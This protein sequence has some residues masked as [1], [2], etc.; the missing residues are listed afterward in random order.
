MATRTNILELID[1]KQRRLDEVENAIMAAP[2]PER[3]SLLELSDELRRELRDLQTLQ[4][5]I[6]A[7][8]RRLLEVQQALVTLPKEERTTWEAIAADLDSQISG[9][10]ASPT[11][12][13]LSPSLS[14]KSRSGK[15]RQLAAMEAENERLRTEAVTRDRELREHTLAA[16]AQAA[17]LAEARREAAEARDKLLKDLAEKEARERA[18]AVR[19]GA[20]AVRIQ[21]GYRGTRVRSEGQSKAAAAT[22][23]QAV[24]RGGRVREQQL[25]QNAAST[26]IQAVFRG[27]RARSR[28]EQRFTS[29][30]SPS[31]RPIQRVLAIELA[32]HGVAAGKDCGGLVGRIEELEDL[33]LGEVGEGPL[34]CRLDR[35]ESCLLYTSSEP[36]RLLSISYAVFCLKKKKRKKRERRERIERK[37]GKK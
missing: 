33:L 36:T 2:R 11:T 10:K 19:E 4:S 3:A 26:S 18:N 6:H 23:V 15:L 1:S 8:Q 5:T 37:K 34:T 30:R 29:P 20:A 27:R 14:P 9:L 7:K 22:R 25:I 16:E 24:Y 32:V 13:S 28:R 31:S 17:A 12:G 35:L 21:A